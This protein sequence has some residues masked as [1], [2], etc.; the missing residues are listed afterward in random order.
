VKKEL[1]IICSGGTS[2]PL[3]EAAKLFEEKTGIKTKPV[4]GKAH[5]L[6]A[7]V[8]ITKDADLFHIGA[9]YQA[10]LAEFEGVIERETRR[11]IG[12][13]RSV[14]AVPKGNEKKIT[15]LEDLAQDGMN[16][17]VC[18]AGCLSGIWDDVVSRTQNLQ[19]LRKIRNNI[20]SYSEGCM[21]NCRKLIEKGTDVSFGWNVFSVV[22]PEKIECIEFPEELQIRRST[23]ISKFTFCRFHEE[24]EKFLQFMETDEVRDIYKKYGWEV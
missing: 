23:N 15:C 24:A 21:G 9:E 3:V 1:R 22:F 13:R 14:L 4:V 8:K 18:V 7:E 17:S 2:V 12:F 5:V 19:L 16:V 20:T 6:Y 11:V 10:D